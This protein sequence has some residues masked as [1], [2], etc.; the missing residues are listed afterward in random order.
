MSLLN[1]RVTGSD[2]SSLLCLSEPKSYQEILELLKGI[3]LSI[4][5]IVFDCTN[6]L[7]LD[8]ETLEKLRKDIHAMNICFYIYFFNVNSEALQE[9]LRASPFK[10]SVYCTLAD[11]KATYRLNIATLDKTEL[12]TTISDV[13]H[14]SDETVIADQAKN[15]DVYVQ[16]APHYQNIKIRNEDYEAWE[17]IIAIL[18]HL[19]LPPDCS[20]CLGDALKYILRLG[21]K[22]E[23]KVA[24]TK[25]KK[26][27]QDLNKAIYYLQK[28][29]NFLEI[30]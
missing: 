26:T 12:S 30:E 19:N 5:A 17:I 21:K 4:R 29:S 24:D 10:S 6:I 1:D 16:K 11:V 14:L 22:F 8:L 27:A 28:A 25:D 13:L 15:S 2:Y 18:D 9:K 20:W 3:K 23:D 7:D